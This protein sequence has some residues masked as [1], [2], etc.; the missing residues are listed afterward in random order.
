MPGKLTGPELAAA[1]VSIALSTGGLG[2]A[3]KRELGA[4]GD[5]GGA[6]AGNRAGAS[7]TGK[8][9]SFLKRS[10]ATVGV[11]AGVALGAVIAKGLGG[12]FEQSDATTKFKQ[13]L[14]FAGITKGQIDQATKLTQSYADKTVFDLSTV[15]NTAAQLA[16]NGVKDFTGLTEAAGNL[17][18]VAGGN[19]DSFRS[20]AMAMTQ[21]VGAGKLTTENWNQIADAIPGASGVLQEAMR[22]NGA[23]TGDF[24]DAMA[25]SQITAEEFNK[26]LMEVG[27]RPIAVEAAKSTATFE[28][29]M[30]NMMATITGGFAKFLNKVKPQLTAVIGAISTGFSKGFDVV[31]SVFGFIGDHTKLFGTLAAVVG[32]AA[33]AWALW[34]GAVKAWQ[35]AT[36]IATA[37]QVAFNA[38]MNANPVMLVV[39][40]IAALT[41]G[42]VYLWNNSEGFR[43]FWIGLW[44]TIKG[45]VSAVIDWFK[46]LPDTIAGIFASVIDW[47]TELPGKIWGGVT[48]GAAWLT[49][50][51]GELMGWILD[52]IESTA[53]TVWD[54]F[55]NL[56]A[57]AWAGV[58]ALVTTITGYGTDFLNW[59]WDGIKAAAG[60]VWTWFAALPA[61]AWEGIKGLSAW[62]IARGSE[63]LDWIWG[64]IKS[65][66]TSVW[67][68]FSELPGYLWNGFLSVAGTTGSWLLAKGKQILTWIWDGVK[69][70]AS[71]VWNWFADIPNK[72]WTALK[73]MWQRLIDFGKEIIN[74]IVAGI[75]A[76]GSAIWNA[77][78][79]LFT[80]SGKSVTI[81]VTVQTTADSL[82][83]VISNPG[84][85]NSTVQALKGYYGGGRASGGP[86]DPSQFYTVGEN[87]PEL[88]VPTRSGRIVPNGALGSVAGGPRIEISQTIYN[89]TVESDALAR[90]RALQLAAALGGAL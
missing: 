53:A 34:T 68:W 32:T 55:T 51:A 18:A 69:S 10:L 80:G 15:Q 64:G 9:G 31:K 23:F 38:V 27:T 79:S 5:E 22:K 35:L 33:A 81:P 59:I 12:A 74:K 50:K 13:S 84:S 16:A 20:V 60:A 90:N 3:L 76:T 40:A 89:P 36:K 41:A 72:I 7:L 78:T 70:V 49:G 86:V 25:K 87:G 63:F 4:A 42:F 37:V 28:G 67:T 21:T 75:K 46:G 8:L 17:T 73:N 52:G 44:N 48:S 83:N 77:I 39:T 61:K 56:P 47:F 26:A 19:A 82:K 88:F 71:D 43:N 6:E 65:A 2:T 1:Y 30:G 58:V 45:A 14:D 66:A 11:T 29:A 85:T 24:R 54:W 62:I 57:T